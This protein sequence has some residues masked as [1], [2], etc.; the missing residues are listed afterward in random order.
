MG[1][2]KSIGRIASAGRTETEKTDDLKRFRVVLEFVPRTQVERSVRGYLCGQV[3]KGLDDAFVNPK[4]LIEL[5]REND[6]PREMI[7]RA[8]ACWDM[9]RSVSVRETTEWRVTEE[10]ETASN[11]IARTWVNVLLRAWRMLVGSPSERLPLTREYIP[12]KP[13]NPDQGAAFERWLS[14]RDKSFM[15]LRASLALTA[16]DLRSAE[17]GLSAGVS[18]HLESHDTLELPDRLNIAATPSGPALVGRQ[19]PSPLA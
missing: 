1:F 4:Q 13:T 12:V 19:S 11:A 7:E 15:A 18:G 10:A 2:S 5:L 6:A 8:E 17:K 16:D 14:Y 3:Q 9:Y